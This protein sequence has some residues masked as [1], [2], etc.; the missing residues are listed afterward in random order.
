MS[1][2]W[3]WQLV[4]DLVVKDLRLITFFEKIRLESNAE[5]VD[6]FRREIAQ[7]P[8]ATLNRPAPLAI[9]ADGNKFN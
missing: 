2:A 5:G 1:R 6:L 9:M 7:C 4:S 8:W 3:R